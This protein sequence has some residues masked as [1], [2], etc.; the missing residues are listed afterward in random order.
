LASQDSLGSPFS[1]W[2]RKIDEAKTG[3]CVACNRKLVYRSNGKKSFQS[4]AADPDHVAAVKAQQHTSTLP[5]AEPVIADACISDRVTGAKLWICAWP[6]QA[7]VSVLQVPLMSVYPEYG[8]QTVRQD[9]HGQFQPRVSAATTVRQNPCIM[10]SRLQGKD[11]PASG[12]LYTLLSKLKAHQESDLQA[13]TF[14]ASSPS[15]LS[16]TIKCFFH[17]VEQAARPIISLLAARGWL[18]YHT[19]NLI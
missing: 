10:W 3:Y 17:H 14:E 15:S 18:S 9:L 6:F 16:V 12:W 13:Q 11:R 7:V 5:T 4:H 2:L 19:R 1:N 8:G